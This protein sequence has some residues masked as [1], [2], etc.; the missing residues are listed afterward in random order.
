M[1]W[2]GRAPAPPASEA[3]QGAARSTRHVLDTQYRDRRDRH[4]A[5]AAISMPI[6]GRAQEL[7]RE[8][9]A[10]VRGGNDLRLLG[11]TAGA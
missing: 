3:G 7:R 6:A 11:R 10:A 1:G 4:A 8:L 2:S 5:G 9:L